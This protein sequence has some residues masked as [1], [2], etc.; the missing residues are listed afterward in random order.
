ME[1]AIH[2]KDLDQTHTFGE[3]FTHLKAFYPPGVLQGQDWSELMAATSMRVYIG[4]EFCIH[5]LPHIDELAGVC[6]LVSDQNEGLT[7]LTPPLTDEGLERSTPLFDFL[8]DNNPHAE[9]VVND[10][11]V[12]LF[13]QQYYPLL[14]LSLGRLLN[15]GFKDPRLTNPE[16]ASGFSAE[17]AELFNRCTFDSFEFL[18]KIRELD[19]M[20]L[21]RDLLPYAEPEIQSLR[22]VESSVYFPF[23]YISTGRVCW[24][25]SFKSTTDKKYAISDGCRRSCNKM[26]LNLN[27]AGTN[28]QLFQAGNTI[29]YLYAPSKLAALV[30]HA[31]T[32]NLRLVYQGLIM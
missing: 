28:L 30:K 32:Y 27:H 1:L 15:K 3:I 19:I 31:K 18:A 6:R 10:W 23:G 24:V 26:S 7:F 8:K 4:D 14:R 16:E 25:A 5:R 29:F 20:R 2:I 21:E 9:V 13:L 11:G 22:E 17:T 12:L